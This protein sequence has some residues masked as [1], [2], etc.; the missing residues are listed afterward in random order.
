MLNVV[1]LLLLLL[2]ASKRVEALLKEVAELSGCKGEQEQD[3]EA[4]KEHVGDLWTYCRTDGLE[5]R[6]R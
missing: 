5:V 4:W 2:S 3:E 6:W 1:L